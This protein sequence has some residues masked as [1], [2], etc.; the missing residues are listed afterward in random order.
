[1]AVPWPFGRWW[2]DELKRGWD[3]LFSL[4]SAAAGSI[5]LPVRGTLPGDPFGAVVGVVRARV[6]GKNRTFRVNGR[7]VAL[8]LDDISVE[9]TD[10]ARSMGQYGEVRI[11]AR[12]IEWDGGRLERMEIR[13]RN[14]HLRPAVSPTLV[15]APVRW[16]ALVAVSS[17]SSWWASA[18]SRFDL[19]FSAG[20]PHIGLAGR[21]PWV[22]LE[23]E[24][25]AA[26]RSIRLQP[27]ALRLGKWRMP[28]RLPAHHVGLRSLPRDVVLTAVETDSVGIVVRGYLSEWRRSVSLV[29]VERFVAAL[30]VDTARIDI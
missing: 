23:L 6:I 5:G 12:D 13:A 21:R 10:L 27:R 11:A 9:G 15:A 20:V 7:D 3:D 26:G 25:A 1:M 28:L 4:S 30:L 2:M 24:A 17:A 19:A 22:R 14:V 8:I 16:E 18:A 29:D